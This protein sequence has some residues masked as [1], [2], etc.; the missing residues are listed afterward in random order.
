MSQNL[1]PV[2]GTADWLPEQMRRFHQVVHS[3]REVSA[4]FGFAEVM[5]KLSDYRKPDPGRLE[6]L[7]FFHHPSAR[8]RIHDAMRWREAIPR[9]RLIWR[10]RYRSSRAAS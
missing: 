4:R 6:E 5:L 3:A 8:H 10:T 1:Q 9:T 7:V 2:R